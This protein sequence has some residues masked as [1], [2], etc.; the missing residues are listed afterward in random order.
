[1]VKGAL[2]SVG[3]KGAWGS[4]VVKGAWDSVVVKGAWGSV[5]VKGAWG[6]VVVK[7]LTLLV[8]RSRDRFPVVSLDFSVTYFLPNVHESGVDSAPSE[9][10]YHE[11]SWR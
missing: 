8:R 10:E 1:V 6:S 9:N 3:V 2:G 4:V 11:N 5:V 7:V